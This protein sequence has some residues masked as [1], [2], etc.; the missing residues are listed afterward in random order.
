MRA[1]RVF[2]AY[3][4]GKG[5]EIWD[6]GYAQLKASV[7]QG[8]RGREALSALKAAHRA[9][10]EKLLKRIYEYGFLNEDVV[11]FREGE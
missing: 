5:A 1:A 11:R 6:A 2:Y 7:A 8:E 3:C 4:Y 10:G 9:L